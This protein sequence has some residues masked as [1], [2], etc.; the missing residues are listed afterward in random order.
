MKKIYV[1][2]WRGY[3]C[4]GP[5]LLFV[6]QESR[7]AVPKTTYTANVSTVIAR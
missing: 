6:F 1:I 7:K 2:R 5:Y 3:S 4:N